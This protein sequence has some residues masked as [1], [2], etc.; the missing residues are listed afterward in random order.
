MNNVVLFFIALEGRGRE[1]I[2]L[3][4]SFKQWQDSETGREKTMQQ[5]AMIGRASFYGKRR[6]KVWNKKTVDREIKAFDLM[7]KLLKA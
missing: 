5:A 7:K 1:I 4:M 3:I 6:K 2:F